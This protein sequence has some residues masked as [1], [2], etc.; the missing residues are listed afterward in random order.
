MTDNATPLRATPAFAC[1]L[2]KSALGVG[3]RCAA[4]DRR[5][6]QVG[7]VPILLNESNSVFLAADYLR[8]DTAYGGASAYSGHLDKRRGLR[9]AYRRFVHRLAEAQTVA[10]DF[11]V[12]DAMRWI[13]ERRPGAKVLVIGAGDTTLEGDVTY[14]DVAFGK[15]VDCIADAHDL[16]FVDQ[17]FDACVACAVLEH[18]ADPQRCVAEIERVLKPGGFVFA[19]TPFMQ[20]VHMGAYDFTRFTFLGHRRLFG[21]FDEIRSGIAGGPATS[22]AHVFRYLLV[23]LSG[24]PVLVKWLR[25]LGLL[26]T[27]PARYLDLLTVKHATAFDAASGFYFFGVLRRD[28]I[29]DRE[30]LGFFRGG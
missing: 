18:V 22:A 14:T 10:R 29:S 23:S 26:A 2:H 25:L 5:F 8:D 4:C 9:Q 24:R 21:R 13:A 3:F 30:I 12:Q 17:S 16:P 11:D 15:N 7:G 28:R 19:E 1:P 20:P 27:W 6:P